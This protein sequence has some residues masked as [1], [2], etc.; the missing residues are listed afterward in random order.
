[1][2][3]NGRKKKQKKHNSTSINKTSTNSNSSE[4]NATLWWPWSRPILQNQTHTRYKI[5]TRNDRS[6]CPRLRPHWLLA[7]FATV[8]VLLQ[9]LLQPQQREVFLAK[10]TLKLSVGTG[11]GVFKF[12][13]PVDGQHTAGCGRSVY[14]QNKTRQTPSINHSTPIVILRHRTTVWTQTH[15]AR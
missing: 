2:I 9:N 14:I 1:M 10:C 7:T 11:R 4:W 6:G 8:F 13:H 15:R 12:N 5:H 3:P